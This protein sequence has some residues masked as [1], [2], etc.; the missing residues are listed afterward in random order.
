MVIDYLEIVGWLG[1]LLLTVCG[2]PQA[3]KS[4]KEGHSEGMSMSFL[5]MWFWGEVLLTVYVLPKMLYPLIANYVLNIFVAG[6]IL[7]YKL[8][9]RNE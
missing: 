7:W 8:R 5:Q 9:P 2:I 1:G 3:W 6:I 4:Y